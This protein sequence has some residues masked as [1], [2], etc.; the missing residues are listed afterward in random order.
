MSVVTTNHYKIANYW[1]NYYIDKDGTLYSTDKTPLRNIPNTAKPVINDFGEPMCWGCGKPIISKN[2]DEYRKNGEYN[3]LWNDKKVVSK[4]NRCHII[5][6]SL[7]G[8][9]EPSNLFLMCYSCH[10]E[11]PDTKNA[12]SFF[13]WVYQRKSNWVMGELH[14][15]LILKLLEDEIKARNI[16]IEMKDVYEILKSQNINFEVDD[17]EKWFGEHISSHAS[18]VVTSSLICGT[19][20]FLFNLILEKSLSDVA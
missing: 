2:E 6:H 1:K 5:P 20:D 19:V 13:R 8:K 18:S 12:S 4:L 9:D 16:D 11:S 15:R 3:K 14:P 7:G 10:F 17:L